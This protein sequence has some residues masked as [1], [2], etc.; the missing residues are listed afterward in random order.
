MKKIY[1][2]LLDLT[3]TQKISIPSYKIL[4]A[5]NTL[6][7]NI[8]VYAVHDSEKNPV[9]YEFKI[10]PTGEDIDFDISKFTFLGTV[11]IANGRFVFHIFYALATSIIN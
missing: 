6:M 4:S 7:D 1:K 10:V 11:K 3:A 5:E 8:C 9:D 2:Y